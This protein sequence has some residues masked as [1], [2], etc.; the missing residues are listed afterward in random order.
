MALETCSVTTDRQGRELKKHGTSLFPA[1]CYEDDLSAEGVPWHW[2]DELEAV[3]VAEGAAVVGA[4]GR[5]YPVE[6][7]GGFFL[8]PGTLHGVW[9]ASACRLRSLVFHPRLVGGGIDSIFWQGY[10]APLLSAAP[11]CILLHRAVPWEKAALQAV[12]TAWTA[13]IAEEAGYEFQV[14]EALSRL[15]F[16]LSEHRPAMPQSPSEKALRDEERIK[17]M[18]Q[19][20]HAHFQESLTTAQIAQSAAVSESECLRCFRS[21]TGTPPIQYVRQFRIQKA[22]ELLV[23]TDQRISDIGALCG[24]QEMSYFA[25]SFREAKGCTPS[26]YRAKRRGCP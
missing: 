3:L 20:I 18:L 2:H 15:V 22:A 13:C 12:E 19:Y 7:G 6:Q 16:L 17:T 4:A 10:L 23:C 9:A 1:A 21:M 5:M 11:D 8:R 26:A 25:R 14:R 24:F